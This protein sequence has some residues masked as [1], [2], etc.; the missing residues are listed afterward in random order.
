MNYT[1]IDP[2]S[3]LDMHRRVRACRSR[4]AGRPSRDDALAPRACCNIRLPTSGG[5]YAWEFERDGR[6]AN[7]TSMAPVVSPLE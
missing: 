4:S 5:L 6:S 7:V 2:A 1:A 3:S